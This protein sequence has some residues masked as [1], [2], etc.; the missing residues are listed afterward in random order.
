MLF[1]PAGAPQETLLLRGNRMMTLV[2]RMFESTWIDA[3]PL[4]AARTGHDLPDVRREGTPIPLTAQQ[5]SILK[6]LAEG[7]TD[8]VIA[9]KMGVTVRT[10]TRRVAEIYSLLDVESRFQAGTAARRLG[11]V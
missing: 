3:F 1:F 8:Q 9:K 6:Y 4:D 2:G 7:Q 11:L 10:V 5:T